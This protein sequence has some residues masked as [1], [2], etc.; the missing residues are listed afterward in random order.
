[1]VLHT[2]FLNTITM[3][4]KLLIEKYHKHKIKW[5]P[6]TSLDETN[7]RYNATINTRPTPTHTDPPKCSDPWISPQ[8]AER[9][10]PS[11]LIPLLRSSGSPVGGRGMNSCSQQK[12]VT[13]R[14]NTTQTNG[15]VLNVPQRYKTVAYCFHCETTIATRILVSLKLNESHESLI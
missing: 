8:F 2:L 15:S 3:G 10:A 9:M 14:L 6:L 7:C 1:M 13:S 4:K 11:V 5:R 12:H